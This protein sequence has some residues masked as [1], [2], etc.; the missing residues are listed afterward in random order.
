LATLVCGWLAA[1]PAGAEDDWL[2]LTTDR[3]TV[4]SELGERDTRRWAEEL[5]QFIDA[6]HGLLPLNQR[7]LP[8]LTAVLFKRSGGFSRYRLRTESGLVGGNSAVFL[9]AGTWSLIGMAGKS[10]SEDP[11]TYHE[12]VH[13]FMS[14]D[15]ARYP[16]WF[17][18]GVAEAFSTFDV[19]GQ[20]G[21]W[22]QSIDRH[23]EYLRFTGL[24]PMAQFLEVT[25]DE[26]M[27]VNA[28]YYPQAW[29]FVHYLLFGRE[30][31][32][33]LLGAFLSRSQQMSPGPAF[34][35]AFG[36]EL[37][38]MDR[39][40]RGYLRHTRYGVGQVELDR[41]DSD[42]MT[43]R[44]AA[45]EAVELSL[46][47][48]ALGTGNDEVMAEHVAALLEVAPTSAEAYDLLAL[49]KLRS[50]E[51][52][53]ELEDLLDRAI[54]LDSRD[55]RTYEMRAA[56]LFDERGR[57]G[58]LFAPEA[59]APEDARE[60]ADY[61][62]RSIELMPVNLDAFRLHAAA[63]LSVD[64]AVDADRRVLELGAAIFPRQGL[65]AIGRAA[66]ALAEDDADAALQWLDLALGDEHELEPDDATAAS[67]LRNGLRAAGRRW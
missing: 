60:I 6:L 33:A 1:V 25:Q 40:L 8:P 59:L 17:T 28:A 5:D 31:G 10:P 34:D 15:P 61:A 14:A 16:L 27:H 51:G 21:Y 63:L 24:Q 12:A 18:E 65:V 2:E 32:P 29:L 39:L 44:P 45:R 35:A 49:D 53:G 64:A 30:D 54:A 20:R 67:A 41:P 7:L 62:A 42:A 9:N 19:T 46:A 11:T 58:S 13:W 47:R 3:F 37:A 52:D 56:L 26:A 50:N 48:L 57:R 38:E 43:V 4:I 23:L 66:L 22:G 55:S 36:M